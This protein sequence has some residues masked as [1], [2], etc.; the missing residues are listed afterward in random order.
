[1]RDKDIY[2][3]YYTKACPFCIK[4]L[5]AIEGKGVDLELVDINS[6][7]GARDKL[8][9][10]GGKTMVPCLNYNDGVDRWMYESD[11]IIAFLLQG[12]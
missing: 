10:N 8:L 2:A 5:R 6:V 11:D 12:K 4:V 3:L 9:Q 1:M 7:A